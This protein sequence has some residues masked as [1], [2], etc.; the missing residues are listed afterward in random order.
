[1]SRQI[2]EA[3]D[4]VVD[5]V[6]ALEGLGALANYLGDDALPWAVVHHSIGRYRFVVEQA[7]E[8]PVALG[9]HHWM[10]RPGGGHELRR[11]VVYIAA[12]FGADTLGEVA[13]HTQ[14]AEA[15]SLYAIRRGYAPICV[16]SGAL[17]GAYGR[18]TDAGDRKAALD[19]D[20]ALLDVSG[21]VW[22]LTRD[23]GTLSPG[24][25][26][27]LDHWSSTGRAPWTLNTWA[28]WSAEFD[29]FHVLT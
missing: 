25:L 19:V 5:A 26:V 12:P 10:K 13:A 4:A 28:G 6:A 23:D 18:D 15:L 14:R 22:A 17:R 11:P 24:M 8:Q 1:M 2:I 16:H 21:E 7:V 27:E 9:G 29:R 3:A 20:L